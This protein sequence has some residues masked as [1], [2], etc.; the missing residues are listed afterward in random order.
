MT[1]TKLLRHSLDS[2]APLKPQ[3]RRPLRVQGSVY[4]TRYPPDAAH[5]PRPLA[6]LSQTCSRPP[7]SPP[8]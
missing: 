3:K 2:A 1:D 8:G 4:A 7:G 5:P 6:R